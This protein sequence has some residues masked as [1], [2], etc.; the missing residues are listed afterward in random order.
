MSRRPQQVAP[1]GRLP[2]PRRT[3]LADLGLGFT[4][5]ALGTLLQRD[6]KIIY[7]MIDFELLQRHEDAV[8]RR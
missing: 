7:T 2:P 8:K 6:G 4:G 1:D 3:F 5:L